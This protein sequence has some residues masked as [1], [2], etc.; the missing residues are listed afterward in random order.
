MRALARAEALSIEVLLVGAEDPDPIV[1]GATLELVAHRS[2]PALDA[3]VVAGLE[4]QEPQVIE[5]AAWTA[6]ERE[7][8]TDAVIER[9]VVLTAGARRRAG[10]RSSGRRPGSDR[11]RSRA[12]P[13]SWGPRTTRRPSGAGPCWPSHPSRAR[14]STPP[15]RQRAPTATG[16]CARPPKT[17]SDPPTH[18]IL[19]RIRLLQRRDLY[20]VRRG[21]GGGAQGKLGWRFSRNAAMPSR[22]SGIWLA[23]AMTSTARVYASASGSPICS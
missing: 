9:L 5:T 1:R 10:A 21:V 17:S 3:V 18:R 13:R 14:K 7:R 4:D 22:A 19:V 6:G 15:S 12:W 20:Q 8:A 2:E 23:R 16:K 11:R